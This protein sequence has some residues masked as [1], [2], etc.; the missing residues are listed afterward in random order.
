MGGM[1]L[2]TSIFTVEF[3]ARVTQSFAFPVLLTSFAILATHSSYL[4][5]GTKIWCNTQ[6]MPRYGIMNTSEWCLNRGY[7]RADAGIWFRQLTEN[8]Q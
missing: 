5:C 4:H 2:L 6:L 3:H 8:H 7:G 1:S